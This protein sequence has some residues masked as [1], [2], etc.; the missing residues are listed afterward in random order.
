M[1]KDCKCLTMYE[2]FFLSYSLQEIIMSRQKAKNELLDRIN[3]D[4]VA[5]GATR[6]DNLGEMLIDNYNRII[7]LLQEVKDSVDAIPMC[8]NESRGSIAIVREE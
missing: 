8:E 7:E 1:L 3:N 5:L 4:W 6:E 2:Q